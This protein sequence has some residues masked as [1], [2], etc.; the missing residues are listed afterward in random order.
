MICRCYNRNRK[1]YKNYGGR[2]I[3][4]CEKWRKFENFYDDMKIG[5]KDTLTLDRVNNDGNYELANCRWATQEQQ[6]WNQRMKKLT[7]EKVK[8]IRIKYENGEYGIGRQL[9]KEYNVTPIVI[10]EIVNCK[11]N[12]AHY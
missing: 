2:G 3:T 9:A 11:R 10:S 1:Q 12:Y 6:H 8:E 7:R 5:Y 4:V